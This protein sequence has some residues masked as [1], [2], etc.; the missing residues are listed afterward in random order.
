MPCRDSRTQHRCWG[1]AL[2]E[3]VIALVTLDTLAAFAIPRLE[4]ADNALE[5]VG[6]AGL[7]EDETGMVTLYFSPRQCLIMLTQRATLYLTRS[8]DLG[9]FDLQDYASHTNALSSR[10]SLEIQRS[11]DYYVQHSRQAAIRTVAILPI[12]ITLYGLEDARSR[13]SALQHKL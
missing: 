13:Y 12:P 5:V 11:I 3:L 8:S 9:Y 10:L 4:P 7:P 1:F 6:I 2:P